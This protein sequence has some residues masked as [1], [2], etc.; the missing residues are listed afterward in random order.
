MILAAVMASLFVPAVALGDSAA[1][2]AAKPSGAPVL[3]AFRGGFHLGGGGF[4]RR[5]FGSGAFGR[6]SSSRGLLHRVA[7]A[8]A[9]AYLLHLFFSHGGLSIVIWLLVIGLLVHLV[10][11]RR[12]ARNR[13]SY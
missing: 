3:L 4:S 1:I 11:R 7:R 13:Y 5:G 2:P 8:L 6:R 12:R 10:R 9:F